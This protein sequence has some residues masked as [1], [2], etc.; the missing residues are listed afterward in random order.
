MRKL[1]EL[2]KEFYL[3]ELN[4]YRLYTELSRRIEDD[5]LRTSLERIANMEK[6]HARF[7]KEFLKVRGEDP[8]SERRVLFQSLVLFLGRFVNPLLLVSLL[9]LG[10]TTAYTQ[11][12]TFLKEKG[13]EL[14]SEEVERL[15]GIILD[16]LSHESIFREKLVELGLSSVRDMVLGMNDGLVELLGVV[17]GLSAVYRHEPTVVGASAVVVGVAGALSMGIGAFISV[18]SQRQVNEAL[19]EREMIVSEVSGKSL[20][21]QTVNDENELKSALFTGISYMLGVV[22]PVS[23]YFFMG[24]SIK[25]LALALLLALIILSVVASF[26]AVVSGISLK[27]KI[28]EMVLSAG[29]AAGAS[30]TIGSLVKMLFNLEVP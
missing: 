17:A 8:P 14:S 29:F 27:R 1:T 4:D 9:E 3:N 2:A 24:D 28:L 25:A 23:P 6:G 13:G 21:Q 5:Q 19:R 16:E 26:I 20:S 15:K 10:E 30:F 22:F 12:Y 7:W 11:Y 18:R